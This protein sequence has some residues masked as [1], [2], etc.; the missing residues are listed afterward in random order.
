[1][2]N[3]DEYTFLCPECGQSIVVNTPMKD[4]LIDSGCVIC[5]TDVSPGAFMSSSG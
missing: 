3:W 1:M 2:D 5:E 4:A